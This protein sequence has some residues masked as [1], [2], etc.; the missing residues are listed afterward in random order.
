[1]NLDKIL[2]RLKAEYK[3]NTDNI[4]GGWSD[5]AA[6][7]D[8]LVE[9][10]KTLLYARELRI[11][12]ENAVATGAPVPIYEAMTAYPIGKHE[13]YI[14]DEDKALLSYSSLVALE[15]P[16]SA[17]GTN[18]HT[19]KYFIEQEDA[20]KWR[21]RTALFME[22]TN[23]SDQTGMVARSLA[24]RV[25]Q[26]EADLQNFYN[27]KKNPS[28][29]AKYTSGHY[30]SGRLARSFGGY[31]VSDNITWADATTNRRPIAVEYNPMD[32]I[33]LPRAASFQINGETTP[34][35]ETERV[36]GFVINDNGEVE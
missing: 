6:N 15:K 28:K 2:E 18:I 3:L 21:V 9:T 24:G 26:C 36:P 13:G 5:F 35:A 11:M 16:N 30:T 32:E 17:V 33:G 29:K 31:T 10:I 1:M 22:K 7:D 19:V 4:I 23:T 14:I 12:W 25:A 20:L 27:E 34:I 8:T